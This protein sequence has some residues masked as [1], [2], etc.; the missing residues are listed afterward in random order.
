MC[1][2]VSEFFLNVFSVTKIF[3][4]KGLKP[5]T[6]CV[7]D[8]NATTGP[9]RHVRDRIF[10]LI[11]IHASVIIRSPEFT[12]LNDESFAPSIK[13]SNVVKGCVEGKVRNIVV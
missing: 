13:N 9:A 1:V 10:K 6:S 2:E 3:A 8:Q 4:L 5:A 11:P 7:R 12:E